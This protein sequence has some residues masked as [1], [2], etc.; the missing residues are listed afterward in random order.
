MKF[1]SFQQSIQNPPYV[2]KTTKWSFHDLFMV[3]RGGLRLMCNQKRVALSQG[4]AIL[5]PPHTEFF[6]DETTLVSMFRV[7]H[8]ERSRSGHPE[9][10]ALLNRAEFTHF[11]G[12]LAL[13]HI[14]N[15]LRRI[16]DLHRPERNPR[17]TSL[18]TH[19]IW[20][21][22][23]ELLRATE[24]HTPEIP[25]AAVRNAHDWAKTNVGEART[26]TQVAARARLSE[27]HFRAI[28]RKIYGKPAGLWLDELRM[29]E[30]R[31]LLSSTNLPIKEIGSLVGYAEA[32]AFHRA[33]VRH[34]GQTPKTFRVMNPS[35]V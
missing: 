23:H 30:A 15:I 19:L 35:K 6:S 12:I 7:I 16:A 2:I 26:L 8:F 20:V 29:I 10:D 22:L 25:H 11:S 32:T 14:E 34:H 18:L 21:L 3:E 1:L 33:F 31:R 28:F 27:S 24:T 5:L 17:D 13:S 9:M 4:D